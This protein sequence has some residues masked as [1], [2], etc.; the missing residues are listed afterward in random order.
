MSAL[1]TA[2][3]GGDVAEVQRLLREGA[4]LS[5]LGLNGRTAMHMASDWGRD[6]VAKCLIKEGGADIDGVI[7][8]ATPNI[9]CY[10]GP[11]VK[12]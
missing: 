6:V 10:H 12:W 11:G 2:V 3:A 9:L 5:E 4:S 1:V 7:V 8:R